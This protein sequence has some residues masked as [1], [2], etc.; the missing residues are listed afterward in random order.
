L[1]GLAAGVIL[2]LM[3]LLWAAVA[4]TRLE[5]NDLKALTPVWLWSLPALGLFG[6]AGWL[7]GSALAAVMQIRGRQS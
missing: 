5:G 1:W 2:A 3:L 7:V 4:L 6:G